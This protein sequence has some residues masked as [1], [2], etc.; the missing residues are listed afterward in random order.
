MAHESARCQFV[1]LETHTECEKWYPYDPNQKFCEIHRNGLSA[2]LSLDNKKKYYAEYAAMKDPFEIQKHIVN[3]EQQLKEQIK[4]LEDRRW[5]A[6]TVLRQ[7]EDEMTESDREAL[8]KRTKGLG[9]APDKVV[10]KTPK[11]R[12]PD[13]FAR[14]QNLNKD[15]LM[16]MSLEQIAAWKAKVKKEG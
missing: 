12:K 8:R 7:L 14:Y 11:P 16:E 3:V 4:D 2:T 5:A 13:I 1:D 9:R 15:D 6:N 10:K